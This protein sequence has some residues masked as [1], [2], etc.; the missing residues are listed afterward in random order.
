MKKFAVGQQYEVVSW[1]T[2]GIS[3]YTVESVIDDE[4]TFSVTSFEIDG[5]HEGMETHKIIEDSNG[6]EKVVLFTYS[7]EECAI[8]ANEE[9]K[10]MTNTTFR[11]DNTIYTQEKSGYCYAQPVGGIKKR[12][13]A[14]AFNEAW[15]KQ[16]DLEQE[17]AKQARDEADDKAVLGD[18]KK[19][20]A[21]KARKSKDVAFSYCP[22]GTD[23]ITL[24]AK[25]VDFI[26]H[27]PDT[28]FYENGLDST[29]WCDILADEIGGQFAGKP[30]TVGAMISTLRE[31]SLIRVG[32]DKVNGKRAKYF[33]FTD[34]GKQVATELGLE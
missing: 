5:N 1:F 19:A 9:E 7:D 3:H 12:I 13:S 2:G 11:F 28:N 6:D 8:F 29:P 20:K 26:K 33:A 4:V 18:Q 23:V 21:K 31:K 17:L 15:Q 24:T 10:K 34:M 27:I 25:Q 16:A 30:M 32:V 14:K 22:N